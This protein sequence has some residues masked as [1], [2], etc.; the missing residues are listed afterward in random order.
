MRGARRR[1]RAIGVLSVSLVLGSAGCGAGGHQKTATTTSAKPS[2]GW[3]GPLSD[4]S[5]VWSAQP[6]IDLFTGAAV[7]ARA[8][9][10][11][12][13]LAD[14]QG[15]QSFLYPGFASA[16]PPNEPAD[17]PL[18]TTTRWPTAGGNP[19][20]EPQVGTEYDHI[21]AIAPD[22]PGLTVTS[23]VYLYRTAHQKADGQ[24]VGSWES[25]D[26]NAGILVERIAMSAP[27]GDAAPRVAPQRGPARAPSDNVF[28]GWRV[29]SYL[30]TQPSTEG[31]TAPGYQEAWPDLP[32]DFQTCLSEAP[33]P[34]ERRH[35]L[36]SGE[37]PRLE[38]PT[39]P[40]YPG[41]PAGSSS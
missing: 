25:P 27:T 36:T 14:W 24:Y 38:F 6:G 34:P 13:W 33:D 19:V 30:H 21:L 20:K 12:Y 4:Y 26:P 7:V 37:H 8:Y 18:G 17:H 40:P 10:E 5:L 28:G 32:R 23:C 11:S 15:S 9:H 1:W 39:Q 3:T 22:G 16:V 41:W 31:H 35:F 2:T 29:T